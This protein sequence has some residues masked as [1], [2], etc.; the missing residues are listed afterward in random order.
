MIEARF[1]R[2]PRPADWDVYGT[3]TCILPDGSIGQLGYFISKGYR[4][5]DGGSYLEDQ[6]GKEERIT[7]EIGFSSRNAVP[8]FFEQLFSPLVNYLKR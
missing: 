2:V 4:I 3:E 1:Y 8:S 6:A 7:V 5:I